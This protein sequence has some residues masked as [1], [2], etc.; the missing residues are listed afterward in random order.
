MSDKHSFTA[1]FTDNVVGEEAQGD[2]AVHFR[3]VKQ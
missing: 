2:F 3:R 1:S